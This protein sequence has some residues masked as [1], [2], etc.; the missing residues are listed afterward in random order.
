MCDTRV[1]RRGAAWCGP[2]SSSHRHLQ[3]RARAHSRTCARKHLQVR[4]STSLTVLHARSLREADRHDRM[5]RRG[6]VPGCAAR[7]HEQATRDHGP[8]RPREPYPSHPALTHRRRTRRQAQMPLRFFCRSSPFTRACLLLLWRTRPGKS[9]SGRT[10]MRACTP[11][12]PPS[13]QECR[14]SATFRLVGWSLVTILWK[15][16]RSVILQSGNPSLRWEGDRFDLEKRTFCWEG[17]AR[18]AAGRPQGSGTD[19]ES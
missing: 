6:C 1:M 18:F 15:I 4:M 17:P 11:A 19:N 5:G 10:L 2:V 7:A 12:E 3:V 8:V 16:Q 14:E 9:G 13:C